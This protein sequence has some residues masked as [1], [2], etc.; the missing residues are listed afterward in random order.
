MGTIDNSGNHH[1]GKGTRYGGQFATKLNS[2]PTSESLGQVFGQLL[3]DRLDDLP[4]RPTVQ[5]AS[6]AIMIDGELS[7][8]SANL[9]S[10]LLQKAMEASRDNPDADVQ[11]KAES[12]WNGVTGL[13]GYIDHAVPAPKPGQRLVCEYQGEIFDASELANRKLTL[14]DV[15]ARVEDVVVLEPETRAD[16]EQ[17]REALTERPGDGPVLVD[18]ELDPD[19]PAQLKVNALTT[20]DFLWDGMLTEDELNSYPDV[21]DDVFLDWFGADV[22]GDSWEAADITIVGTVPAENATESIVADRMWGQWAKFRN[23]TDPGTFGRPYV[24]AEIRRRIDERKN[25]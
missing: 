25:G 4:L 7:A 23:E 21:V 20:H 5:T 17:V 22:S 19:N 9:D 13:Y 6:Y 12:G 16:L 11:V 1:H 14:F 2:A 18:C 15:E 8:A 24:G 10:G 3:P